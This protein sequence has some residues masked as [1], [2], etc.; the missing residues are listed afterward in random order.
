MIKNDGSSSTLR[1]VARVETITT[2]RWTGVTSQGV[3]ASWKAEAQEMTDDSPVL[4]EVN[5]DVHRGDAFLPFSWELGGGPGAT[6]DA[7]NFVAEMQKLLVDASLQLE[8]QAFVHGT[9]VGQPH[10]FVDALSDV[11]GSVVTGSGEAL[12][13]AHLYQ[14]QNSLGPR[15]QA[16]ASWLASLPILNQIGQFESENGS[17]LHSAELAGNRLLRKPINEL[18]PMDGTVDASVTADNYLLAYGDWR[19]GLVLVDRVGSVLEIIPHLFGAANRPT[20]Q[21]G[22]V[23]W[24]RTGSG[25]VLPEA[26]RLLKIH[27]TA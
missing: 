12:T 4:G 15:F 22:A 16:G 23:L 21:R 26:L 27:T 3:T 8:T 14:V 13:S 24:R 10:G 17:P 1:S 6:G 19:Q 2:S 7:P 25:V 9:G 20:G 18:S 11:P 5:I